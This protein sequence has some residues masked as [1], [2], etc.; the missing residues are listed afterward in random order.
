MSVC[1]Y[2]SND[3]IYDSAINV[4]RAHNEREVFF[5]KQGDKRKETP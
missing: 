3:E 2:S 5:N 1:T 4:E